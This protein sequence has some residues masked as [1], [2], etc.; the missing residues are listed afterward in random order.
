MRMA[1]EVSDTLFFSKRTAP[2]EVAKQSGV[3]QGKQQFPT[4]HVALLT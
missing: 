1:T 3:L 2:G 4:S